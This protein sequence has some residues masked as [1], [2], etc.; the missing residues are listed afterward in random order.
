MTPKK[1]FQQALLCDTAKEMRKQLRKLAQPII[2]NWW[3]VS[4][5][6]A[7]FNTSP[8][9]GHAPNQINPSPTHSGLC[10]SLDLS[11]L[12]LIVFCDLHDHMLAPRSRIQLAI[13]EPDI[14]SRKDSS[15]KSKTG[16]TFGRPYDLEDDYLTCLIDQATFL[17]GIF[18]ETPME[19]TLKNTLSLVLI[20]E[21]MDFFALD[22][23]GH[24]AEI[25]T[26]QMSGE[27]DPFLSALAA[28]IEGDR[29]TLDDHGGYDGTY[30]HWQHYDNHY[31]FIY[32]RLEDANVE[33]AIETAAAPSA[34]T[35]PD[36]SQATILDAV[37]SAAGMPDIKTMVTRINSGV[38]DLDAATLKITEL[39]DK[40]KQTAAAAIAVA[41]VVTKADASGAIPSGKVVTKNA[42]EV[43][44][45][46]G[47][48]KAQ[49][50]FNIP[51]WE[52]DGVHP[53][54]PVI[55]PS[56]IFR[57]EEL[58]RGLYALLTNQR[59][60]FYGHTGTGK[61]TLI[62]QMAARLLWPFMR[63]NFDSEITRMDLIGRDTL[64]TEGGV[65]VSKFE[66]GILPQA[67]SG[68]YILCCDE[69]DFV[70]PDVAYVM[71]RALE[72]NGLLLTEDGGRVIEAHSMFR[73]FATGNTQGQGDEH[74]MYAGAR[75]QSMAF[76]DRFTVWCQ[77]DY[78]AANDRKKL[79][80]AKVPSLNDEHLNL[81]CQYTKE[82]LEAFKSAKVMQPLSPR[83][84]ISLA[85]A[86]GMF[87]SMAEDGG[88]KDAIK[89]AFGTTILDRATSTDHAVMRGIVDRLV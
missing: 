60:Y 42:A 25:V 14:K 19:Y 38:R 45:I 28:Y 12:A 2:E 16:F 79:I 24:I 59:A 3:E 49:F 15:G 26:E 35:L 47:A 55:D 36:D 74:G 63:V 71:Q 73:M 32:N 17:T 67:M 8:L 13:M 51:V 65:T 44:N 64:S 77:V 6:Q 30:E 41:P 68:P 27:K 83:G 80:K 89:R 66:D 61:T 50:D 82:H 1:K 78:L 9:V 58:L 85:Q 53:H 76:L 81:V 22:H 56:Y 86:V 20:T 5:I 10:M 54:V 39:Q 43:F 18:T 70:R 57:P 21:L 46:T 37:L 52:W 88:E 87:A 40:V 48:A 23:A 31:G 29:L 34:L 33:T 69:V 11:T 62:E 75:P 84:M 72:G 7:A 4:L